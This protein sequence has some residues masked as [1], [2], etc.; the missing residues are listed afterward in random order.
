MK[1]EF[2]GRKGESYWDFFQRW[3]SEADA[4]RRQELEDPTIWDDWDAAVDAHFRVNPPPERPPAAAGAGKKVRVFDEQYNREVREECERLGVLVGPEAFQ[5]PMGRW[6]P[7]LVKETL[8]SVRALLK[9]MEAGVLTAERIREQFK[10]EPGEFADYLS[11]RELTAVRVLETW[12]K[13]GVSLS[14]LEKAALERSERSFQ[15]ARARE[16]SA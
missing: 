5:Q 8:R 2:V 13:A 7:L 1:R 6:H 4:E 9:D 15:R 14:E 12:E 10:K 11:E 3:W 16:K